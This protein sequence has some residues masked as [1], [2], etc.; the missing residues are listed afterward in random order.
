MRSRRY[1]AP[2]AL[3]DA[4]AHELSQLSKLKKLMRVS[5]DFASTDLKMRK[6]HTYQRVKNWLDDGASGATSLGG[7]SLLP[8]SGGISEE[9]RS[10]LI[11]VSDLLDRLAVQV[12][13][14]TGGRARRGCAVASCSRNT[15][16]GNNLYLI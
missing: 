6:W 4:F 14:G 5:S 11:C 15:A 8:Y 3:Y 13:D 12:G 9:Q 10:S 7:S 16:A 1:E 2:E